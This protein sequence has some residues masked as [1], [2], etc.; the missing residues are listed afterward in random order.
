MVHKEI[1][2]VAP[3]SK[4]IFDDYVTPKEL[5][6]NNESPADTYRKINGI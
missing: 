2:N 4:K 6:F 5:R 1:G 3:F